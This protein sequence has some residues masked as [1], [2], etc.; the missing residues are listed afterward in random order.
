VRNPIFLVSYGSFISNFFIFHVIIIHLLKVFKF[1]F[2]IIK[3][4]GFFLLLVENISV[5]FIQALNTVII[6]SCAHSSSSS[7][8]ED[9]PRV[10]I[11]FS[12]SCGSQSVC[13]LTHVFGGAATGR[14]RSNVPMK[15]HA[16]GP[17]CNLAITSLIKTGRFFPSLIFFALIHSGFTA[18]LLLLRFHDQ[19]YLMF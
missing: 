4:L 9:S 7:L 16:L 13:H 19:V 17:D 3:T 11:F 10:T 2:K 12:A 14:H 15:L 5:N 6:D 1:C 18:H 8:I